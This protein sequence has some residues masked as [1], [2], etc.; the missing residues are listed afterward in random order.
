MTSSVFTPEQIDVMHAAFEAVCRKLRL[1]PSDRASEHVA[2]II[3]DLAVTGV[4]TKE[5]LISAAILAAE[6]L[7]EFDPVIRPSGQQTKPARQGAAFFRRE[8]NRTST[9]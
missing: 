5:A 4:L 1:R 8:E 9:R 2:V 3:V 7:D 6:G